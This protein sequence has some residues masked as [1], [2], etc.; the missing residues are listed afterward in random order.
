[1]HDLLEFPPAD[2]R[3]TNKVGFPPCSHFNANHSNAGVYIEKSTLFPS[4]SHFIPLRKNNY[5]HSGRNKIHKKVY[6]LSHFVPGWG[7][8]FFPL[9]ANWNSPSSARSRMASRVANQSPDVG[10]VNL[11][12]EREE[13]AF[14]IETEVGVTHGEAAR[15]FL[16][17][18]RFKAARAV[19]DH[20]ARF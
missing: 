11:V 8:R 15:D 7:G 3:D 19:E 14:M 1:M 17:L 4:S 13:F 2:G 12:A 18:F 10:A 20:A 6:I 9:C 5:K 16:V